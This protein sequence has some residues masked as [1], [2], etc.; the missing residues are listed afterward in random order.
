[1][2]LR[3]KSE[4]RLHWTQDVTKKQCLAIRT[5]YCV[6]F[7]LSSCTEWTVGDIKAY[8]SKFISQRF[9]PKYSI[10]RKTWNLT[11]FGYNISN[12]QHLWRCEW[13]FTKLS[14]FNKHVRKNTCPK[15]ECVRFLDKR[16]KGFQTLRPITHHVFFEWV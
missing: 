11:D 12:S 10:K 8:H 9:G 2:T 14:L 13:R 3:P 5:K 7:R 4:H 16:K 6:E 15:T 1:M